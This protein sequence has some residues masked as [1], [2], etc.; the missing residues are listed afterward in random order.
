MKTTE[1]YI[2]PYHEAFTFVS[3]WSS[4]TKLFKW[5]T[6]L[7]IHSP[8]KFSKKKLF[9]NLHSLTLI[10]SGGGEGE[11][12]GDPLSLLT[13][14]SSAYH[15]NS[16]IGL[17]HFCNF[18]IFSN[19]HISNKRA[20]VWLSSSCELVYTIL[21]KMHETFS[22]KILYEMWKFWHDSMPHLRVTLVHFRVKPAKKKKH[23]KRQKRC[24][25][26]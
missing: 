8:I 1:V 25:V 10:G 23:C 6:L 9:K 2:L 4:K 14:W 13:H 18:N 19:V 21:E 12:R 20:S 11:W 26:K 17:Q 7:V 24:L 3:G 22:I 5:N 15:N 16:I